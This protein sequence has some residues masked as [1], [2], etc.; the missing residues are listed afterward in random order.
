[1]H[2]CQERSL[3]VLSAYKE[4][5]DITDLRQAVGVKDENLSKKRLHNRAMS[6]YK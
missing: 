2:L 6:N 4:H 3:H 1:M 5:V